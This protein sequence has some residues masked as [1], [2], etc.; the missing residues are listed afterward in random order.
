MEIK[1]RFEKDSSDCIKGMFS[2]VR[3]DA[4]SPKGDSRLGDL[5]PV[6]SGE[7]F[8]REGGVNSNLTNL[9]R[10]PRS[11]LSSFSESTANSLIFVSFVVS[12]LVKKLYSNF[13]VKFSTSGT[14]TRVIILDG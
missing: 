10:R 1:S 14:S 8:C 7:H 6:P 5:S 13:A 12:S 11:L 9:G 2:L 3:R 4:G